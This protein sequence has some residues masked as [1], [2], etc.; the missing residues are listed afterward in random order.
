MDELLSGLAPGLP[1]ATH[2]AI[3]ERAEGIPLYAVET[4]R[5]LLDRG[6]LVERDGAYRPTGEIDTLAVPETLQALISARLDALA[7]EER[8][9]VQELSVLGKTFMRDAA[10]G[11]SSLPGGAVDAGLAGLV[12]KEIL[13]IQADRFSPERGQYGFLQDLVRKVAYDTLS[14]HDR[15]S[16]HLRVATYLEAEWSDDDAEIVEVVASHYVR[17]FEAAP[18]EPDAP[19]IKERARDT[20][21]RAG[22][23]AASL[24]ASEEALRYY[25]QAIGLADDPLVRSELG[26]RASRMAWTA[27]DP[28]AARVRA[29]AAMAGFESLGLSHPAARV[30]GWVGFL[31]WQGG[32][33]DEAIRR[34]EAALS[35]LSGDEPDEDVASLAAETARLHWFRGNHELSEQRN[36][37]A[38]EL[39]EAFRLPEA[40]AHGLNTRALQVMARGRYEEATAL[41]EKALQVSLDAK[42]SVVT[43]RSYQNLV[44]LLTQQDRWEESLEMAESA[45]AHA[46]RIG[47]RQ[48]EVTELAATSTALVALGRWDE[49]LLRL[50]EV[51]GAADAL[52]FSTVA[53]EL[54]SLAPVFVH[55]GALDEA[56]DVLGLL[57]DG[58]SSE[59]VQ[60]RAVYL[61]AEA[62]VL[63]A[64][65]RPDDA[66]SSAL[67]AWA[68]R[69][70]LGLSQDVKEGLTLAIDLSLEMGDLERAESLLGEI[71]ALRPGELYPYLQASGARFGARLAAARGD[72]DG[73]EAG[74]RAAGRIFR[75]ASMRF[76]L[77]VTL[78]EHAEWVQGRGRHV[79]AQSLLAEAGTI[80]G[81]LGA[82][83]WL[84][85]LAGVQG[86]DAVADRSSSGI[87]P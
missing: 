73:P 46:R 12:R 79:E 72:D 11:V 27:G 10:V 66:L 68:L 53:I 70:G 32:R 44:S 42:L 83:P 62:P 52:Q 76:W 45:R 48:M 55:R 34:M 13:S 63:R 16:R 58:Q 37:L 6:L 59:D 23:R 85:R 69:E 21:A 22:E 24:A 64:E 61:S 29:E 38:L 26:E 18:D 77:A 35:V 56:R 50:A 75:E 54:S 19:A 39:A 82:V 80:F 20:L 41:L 4:V 67:G 1:E 9:L 74:F 5:M 43:S 7:S 87:A 65:G 31:D 51:Q 3:L 2:A 84:V 8:A 28:A 25:D 71:E 17:A 86:E 78:L 40:L 15:K 57:P 60:V 36:E 47:D 33:V 14:K 81:E 30:L 49:A